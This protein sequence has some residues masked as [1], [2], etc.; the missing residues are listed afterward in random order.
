MSQKIFAGVLGG[1]GI[2]VVLF[3]IGIILSTTKL[4]ID[5]GGIATNAAVFIGI[6][7]GLLG[8]VGILKRLMY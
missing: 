6:V 3:V 5:L 1:S 2:V 8:I 4:N 7:F